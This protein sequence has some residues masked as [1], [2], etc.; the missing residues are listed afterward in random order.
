MKFPGVVLASAMLVAACA[1]GD[2]AQPTPVAP[3]TPKP[4]LNRDQALELAKAAAKDQGYD[5]SKYRLSTFGDETMGGESEFGFDYLCMPI[6]P[7]GCGFLAV[8]DRRTGAVEIMRG[9]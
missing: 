6:G 9:L 2:H 5:L 7:P 1:G 8:V 4:L 3:T